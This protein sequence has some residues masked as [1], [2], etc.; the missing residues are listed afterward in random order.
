MATTFIASTVRVIP[1]PPRAPSAG[2]LAAFAALALP[3]AAAQM[4]LGVYLPAIY[5][6]HYGIPLALLGTIFLLEK[7][8]G[9]AADP[10]IGALSDRTR[11][12]HGRRRPWIAAGAIVFALSAVA[13]FFPPATV[14]PLYLGA[15][16]FAF[17]LGWSMIWIP[18]LAWS[19]EVTSDYHERT[20]VATYQTVAGASSLLLVLILPTVI[21]QLRPGDPAL[22][23][24]AMGAAILLMLAPA[25]VLTL[26]AL[27]EP[28]PPPAP[29][30]LGVIATLRL[31]A[32]NP[33]LVR[34]LASDFAVTLGQNIRGTLFLFFVTTY[35]GLPQW[36]SGLFLLQFIFGIAAGPIWMKI[37]YRLGKHRAA[38]AGELV[39][40]AINLGLLFVLPGQLPLLLGLT[41]AQ[42]FAQGSGNLMLRSMV[43]DIADEHRLRTGEDRAALFYS[44]FS[45]SLKA[46]MAVAVGIALP[47][48][49]WLGFDAAAGAHNT[50]EALRGLLLVFALG[51]AIAHLISAA[52]V[53]GFPLDQAAHAEVR[54]QLDAL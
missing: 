24:A 27:P 49:A 4:P 13:L 45:I 52:L 1:Q 9:T 20:R 15:A 14:T 39:Q 34:V 8:W 5:A 41:V 53:H 23:L 26:A 44:V 54:R 47:L 21:D 22:K 7:L 30:R 51:P 36:A 33:L 2:R 18:Y 19:G 10:I 25:L 11:S 17:Y 38:V 32:A 43:A 37:G 3:I 48:V 35:V 40:V 12:R 46:A 16:L 28:A 29:P 42:G 50:P 6:Q 31:V